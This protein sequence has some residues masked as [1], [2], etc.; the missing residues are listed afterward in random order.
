MEIAGILTLSLSLV[1]AHRS[2]GP[3]APGDPVVDV[4]NMRHF[5]EGLTKFTA[6]EKRRWDI[7]DARLTNVERVLQAHLGS[8]VLDTCAGNDFQ[9]RVQNLQSRLDAL[10][11]RISRPQTPVG[12]PRPSPRGERVSTES[13]LIEKLNE[14]ERRI[15]ELSECIPCLEVKLEI[16][17][18]RREEERLRRE[19][20]R[21]HE[22]QLKIA[23]EQ[24]WTEADKRRAD[25]ERQLLVLTQAQQAAPSAL[26][27]HALEVRIGQLEQDRED[28]SQQLEQ[29][30]K[31]THNHEMKLEEMAKQ[32]EMDRCLGDLQKKVDEFCERVELTSPEEV[33]DTRASLGFGRSTWDAC[34]CI[35]LG[36]VSVFESLLIIFSTLTAA[37]LELLL[38]WM[39]AQNSPSALSD[40]DV[41]QLELWR[42][43]KGHA[44]QYYDE[45]TDSSLV[46]R[47][48]RQGSPA[49][50]PAMDLE[51]YQRLLPFIAQ[52]GKLVATGRI[53]N[54]V[55]VLL[56]SLLSLKKFGDSCCLWT[57][58]S[59]NTG[60]GT[61]TVRC[62]FLHFAEVQLHSVHWIRARLIQSMIALGRFP[63]WT[64]STCFGLAALIHIYNLEDMLVTSVGLLIAVH[65]EKLAYWVL[66]PRRA[67]SILRSIAPASDFQSRA[68]PTRAHG[69]DICGKL[70][71]VMLAAVLTDLV[72]YRPG[73]ERAETAHDALC[74]GNLDF[75]V[76]RNPGTKVMHVA[77]TS[78]VRA[79]EDNRVNIFVAEAGEFSY[80]QQ[81]MR[82]LTDSPFGGTMAVKEASVQHVSDLLHFGVQEAIDLSPSCTDFDSSPSNR[83]IDE[84]A[85][86]VLSYHLNVE[87]GSIEC[88]AIK[89]ECSGPHKFLVRSLCPVSCSCTYSL[90]GLFQLDGCPRS[91]QG[92]RLADI[93]AQ[94][95]SRSEGQCFK[96]Y[97]KEE[98]RNFTDNAWEIF[99]EEYSTYLNKTNLLEGLLQL[100]NATSIIQ[101]ADERG[102][103]LVGNV[104]TYEF[105]PN[106]CHM[107]EPMFGTW[108]VFC[109]RSC[110][111]GER[112]E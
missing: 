85:S 9:E 99:V 22:E 83:N 58:V 59:R 95:T 11:N 51:S 78:A 7:T 102:C 103:G 42:F 44:V 37:A 104:T 24:R 94:I 63:V 21:A 74:S 69:I 86:K 70:F 90:S 53:I 16:E 43:F 40:N 41:R 112:C 8:G 67:K 73:C 110:G 91:C 101:V 30:M 35:A 106:P 72:V 1:M 47:V 39:I 45:T 5:C 66:T 61:R 10:E 60:E 109:P 84:A 93:S 23:A 26:A 36:K 17:S 68:P 111:L 52:G 108:S 32:E 65:M 49:L 14:M 15:Q 38:G 54:L 18:N 76:A 97:L 77:H 27:R 81:A 6:I 105:A 87:E 75:V 28:A 34:F 82:Q 100:L 55:A 80:W 31:S 29:A 64:A 50:T 98:L 12:T 56:W 62:V 48:C 33:F 13:Q 20:E 25:F 92:D 79:V 2:N 4:L 57:I 3:W 89:K 19:E 88:A 107:S 96:D 71:M 46:A